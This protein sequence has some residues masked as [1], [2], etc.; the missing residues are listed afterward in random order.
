MSSTVESLKDP[1]LV[2]QAALL[3]EHENARLHKRLQELI[4]EIARLKGD[5]GEKQLQL[6]VVRLQE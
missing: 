5:D 1:A 2:R 4:A 3:I 6:E